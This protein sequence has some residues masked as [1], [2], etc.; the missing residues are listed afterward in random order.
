VK[1]VAILSHENVAAELSILG[2]WL[3]DRQLT[4]KRYYREQSWIAD[5]ILEADFLIVLGSPNSTAVGY[6]CE[7]APS[8]IELT[9]RFIATGKP[10][11]GI[12]YGAQILA[13]AIGGEVARREIKNIGFKEF[14]AKTD[15]IDSGSWML[16]HEDMVLPESIE[17]VS[18]AKLHGVDAGAAIV[19]NKENA[20]GVQFHPEVDGDA[21][22]RMIS[23][24]GVAEEKW[25][26][27]ADAMNADDQAH[28]A[29][30][31]ELFDLVSGIN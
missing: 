9:K 21:L 31:Y 17:A 4:F 3:D 13:K 7:S 28:R 15:V 25:R 16:W 19:F 29:R 10:Y 11:F 12:C 6:Q 24:I 1:T 2:D 20:W 27:V 30:A 22:G 8:E 14:A 5:E 18:G 23:A 26:P